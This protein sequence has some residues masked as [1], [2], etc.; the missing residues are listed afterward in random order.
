MWT[1][2]AERKVF[3]M[4]YREDSKKRQLVLLCRG[5]TKETKINWMIRVKQVTT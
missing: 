5:Q 4:I 3:K 1:Q 2:M